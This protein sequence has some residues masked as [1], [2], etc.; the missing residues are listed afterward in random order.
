MNINIDV[1]ESDK[2]GLYLSLAIEDLETDDGDAASFT[3][4]ANGNYVAFYKG[5][6]YTLTPEMFFNA[7]AKAVDSKN[8]V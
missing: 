6:E 4:V 7:V 3:L 2:Q 5:H 1:Q 8:T